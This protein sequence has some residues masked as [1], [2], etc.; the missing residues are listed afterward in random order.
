MES[1]DECVCLGLIQLC[2]PC[3]SIF[4]SPI[5]QLAAQQCIDYLSS[6]YL[7]GLPANV[8]PRKF[9]SGHTGLKPKSKERKKR[10][11]QNC[12][13]TKGWQPHRTA[14]KKCRE[15][16]H[17]GVQGHH[18]FLLFS[19]PPHLTRKRNPDHSIFRLPIP[20]P[21]ISHHLNYCHTGTKPVI[22]SHLEHGRSSSCLV[23]IQ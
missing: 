9:C 22:I 12:I 23:S 19:C 17:S 8:L 5:K 11:N 13:W 4:H 3:I 6:K 7:L 14:P 21:V 20:K 1:L 15:V 16:P 10:A 2:I 18:R